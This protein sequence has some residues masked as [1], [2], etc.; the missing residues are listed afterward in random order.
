MKPW[1]IIF[2]VVLLII[3]VIVIAFN[4]ELYISCKEQRKEI[5]AMKDKQDV[6][7]EFNSNKFKYQQDQIDLL[8]RYLEDARE[9]IKDQN[10][11]LA[12]QKDG[13]KSIQ[14][15]LVDIKAEA[16]AIKQDTIGWQKDYAGAL[17]ELKKGVDNIQDQ[18]RG[19]HDNLNSLSVATP[20]AV[21]PPVPVTNEVKEKDEEQS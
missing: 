16:D 7:L 10:D 6:E 14:T 21:V 4:A 3:S 19:L 9:Q 13:D 12:E 15:S 2:R 5:D 17:A 18:I 1:A 11:A 8:N 20:S